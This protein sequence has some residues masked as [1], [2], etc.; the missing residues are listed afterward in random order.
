METVLFEPEHPNGIILDYEVKYYEKEQET[1]YTILRAKSTN[2]TISGL[3]PD[4][5]YVFQIRARTAAGYGTSSRKCY[6][7]P[8]HTLPLPSARINILLDCSSFQE[9]VWCISI[10][11]AC[12]TNPMDFKHCAPNELILYK[13]VTPGGQ[14]VI[15]HIAAEES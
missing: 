7:L 15:L 14:N 8:L 13:P 3:K 1:S 11:T 2:V 4:T 9:R 10:F 6:F 12:G 5:T